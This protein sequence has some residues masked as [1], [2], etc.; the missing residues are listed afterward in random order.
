MP[1]LSELKRETAQREL[2]K[3]RESKLNSQKL[4]GGKASR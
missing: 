3:R 2:D 4:G 1:F